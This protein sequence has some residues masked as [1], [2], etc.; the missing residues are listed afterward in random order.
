MNPDELIG[1]ALDATIAQRLF[2]LE[3]QERRNSRTGQLDV[4]YRIGRDDSWYLVPQYSLAMAPSITLENELT[5]KGWHRVRL[6]TDPLPVPG[7]PS[8]VKLRHDDGRIV[9][10]IGL[11]EEALCRAALKAVAH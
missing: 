6:A 5:Q 11:G 8:S 3:V 10:A 4:V 2:G 7:E 9:E 1:R